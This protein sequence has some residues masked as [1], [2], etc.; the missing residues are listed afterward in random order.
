MAG[1]AEVVK[2]KKRMPDLPGILHFVVNA[3]TGGTPVSLACEACQRRDNRRWPASQPNHHRTRGYL[4]FSASPSIEFQAIE[5][6][7][8]PYIKGKAACFNER[9]SQTRG[10]CH[11]KY[12]GPI[13][14]IRFVTDQVLKQT[15]KVMQPGLIMIFLHHNLTPE[16]IAFSPGVHSG[17]V[18]TNFSP[19]PPFRMASPST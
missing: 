12:I 1:N 5:A 4:S 8:K 15:C 17:A 6:T 14:C 16:I 19:L 11:R 7:D 9:D 2:R 13:F 3:A 10:R 18:Y